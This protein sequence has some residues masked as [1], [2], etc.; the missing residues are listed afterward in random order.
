MSPI[1]ALPEVTTP[2]N[3]YPFQVAMRSSVPSTSPQI[4]RKEHIDLVTHYLNPVS[5][6]RID[7]FF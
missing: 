6:V 2:N 4:I 3:Y 1:V 7:T 5:Y